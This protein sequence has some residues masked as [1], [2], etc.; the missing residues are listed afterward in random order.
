MT[1][2]FYIGAE[3]WNGLSKLIEECGE[4]QQVGGKLLGSD[5]AI[6]HW[7]GTNLKHRL[8]EEIADLTAAI[9]FFIAAN[10]L[11]TV[12]MTTRSIKKVNLF[13]EWDKREKAN[14]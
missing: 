8:E 7:D 1:T 14:V 6:E 2:K 3:Q 4:V 12:T 13:I 9:Q 5:G 11:D 10:G